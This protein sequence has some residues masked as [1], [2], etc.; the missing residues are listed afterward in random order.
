MT[1]EEE[2]FYGIVM[3]VNQ[4]ITEISCIKDKPQDYEY[5][6]SMWL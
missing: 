1:R 6:C 3:H 2:K 5:Q 4:A